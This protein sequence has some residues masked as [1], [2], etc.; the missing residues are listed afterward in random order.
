MYPRRRPPLAN[1]RVTAGVRLSPAAQE[2][3]SY[4][5]VGNCALRLR[6]KDEARMLFS[7]RDVAAPGYAKERDARATM[8][9]AL[10]KEVHALANLGWSAKTHSAT[11]AELE[12]R[13]PF[14]WWLAYAGSLMLLG[15][16]G[17]IYAVSWMISSR[18][19]LF[20]HEEDDGSV[21]RWGD[22]QFASWQQLDVADRDA[23]GSSQ[24][25]SSPASKGDRVLLG[26][27]ALAGA[28]LVNAAVW[29]FLVLGIIAAVN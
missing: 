1:R 11:S 27:T 23:D 12:T 25:T 26:L 29:F 9:P 7:R 10:A 17:L 19:R 2:Q 21:T 3:Q 13:E 5:A 18:V 28:T 20:L 16:G 14:N 4:A 6:V 24:T 22:T 8:R 15:V